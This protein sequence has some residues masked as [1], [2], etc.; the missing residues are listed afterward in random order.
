MTISILGTEYT[1]VEDDSIGEKNFD[2]MC[3]V[4]SRVITVRPT[5]RLLDDSCSDSD[6]K[7]LKREIL[8]HE[9]IHAMFGESGMSKW[10]D[11][12]DLVQWITIMYP[13]MNE[14][15][16]ELGCSAR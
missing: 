4:F 5:D 3:D 11:N 7:S 10:Q 14:L 1:I 8:R 13:K 9:I 6:R 2:G 16:S 12:E 15:F